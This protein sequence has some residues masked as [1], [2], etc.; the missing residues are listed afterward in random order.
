MF[1]LSLPKEWSIKSWL[2]VAAL[3]AAL[4]TVQNFASLLAYQNLEALTYNVLNQTKILSAAV[5]CYYL[6]GKKQSMVQAVSLLLLSGSALVI[7]KIVTLQSFR[8][9]LGDGLYVTIS[10]GLRSFGSASNARRF[11]HGVIPVLLASFISGLA[12]ALTQKTL[13]GVP[14]KSVEQRAS[15]PRNAYQFSMELNAVSAIILLVS[16]LFSS[17]GRSIAQSGFFHQWTPK[18][19]IPIIT[20]SLGGIVVGLVTKHAGSV[21]K[22][23]ALIFGL[24]LSTLIQVGR[25]GVSPEQL[26]GG[27]LAAVSLWLHTA[28]PHKAPPQ[29]ISS[30]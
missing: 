21:Q 28:H 15:T 16:L 11:S 8:S 7:E 5:C 19:L 13:Q 9:L 27:M 18:T 30:L 22:G 3:P 10:R 4:Y 23:F 17:D 1:S 24:L 29:K 25:S 14:S 12:G 20:N 26:I 6:L 2:A